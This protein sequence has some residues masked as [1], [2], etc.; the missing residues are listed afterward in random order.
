MIVAAENLGDAKSSSE[1]YLYKDKHNK[2]KLGDINNK[3]VHNQSS[4]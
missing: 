4:P 1:V 3:K 2:I